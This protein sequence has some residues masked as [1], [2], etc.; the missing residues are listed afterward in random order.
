MSLV[1][2]CRLETTVP[3]KEVSGNV[4]HVVLSCEVLKL[5]SDHNNAE[6]FAS[7][8]FQLKPHHWQATPPRDVLG[9][10]LKNSH[11]VYSTNRKKRKK[12]KKETQRR[13]LLLKNTRRE[14]L[15][16]WCIHHQAVRYRSAPSGREIN[17]KLLRSCQWRVNVNLPTCPRS[18]LFYPAPTSPIPHHHPIPKPPGWWVNKKC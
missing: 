15:W 13:F 18:R 6:A 4:K 14:I 2:P 9:Q 11:I 17:S 16:K 10:L 12:K 3:F 8:I 5:Y 7:L 1:S